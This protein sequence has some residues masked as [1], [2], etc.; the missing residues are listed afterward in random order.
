MRYLLTADE[1]DA[2]EALRI[3]LVQEVVDPGSQLDRAREIAETITRQAPLG[4][5][6]TLRNARL[7]RREGEAA[8]ATQLI[9]EVQA[10]MG[11]EDVR[12]GLQSFIE[13]RTAVFQGR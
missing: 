10:L 4:V 1:F 8:A 2:E 13:R 9:P 6:G 7:A 12:E 11:T 5:L 3:G